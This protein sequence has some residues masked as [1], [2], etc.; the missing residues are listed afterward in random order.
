[1]NKVK[2]N[3]EIFIPFEEL[4]RNALNKK[5]KVFFRVVLV[6]DEEQKQLNTYNVSNMVTVAKEIQ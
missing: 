2:K 4:P 1:M 3:F 5:I 6:T